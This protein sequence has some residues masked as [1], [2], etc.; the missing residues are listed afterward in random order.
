MIVIT[1][2][3]VLKAPGVR[4]GVRA[5]GVP[6]GGA[7]CVWAG[8]EHES[9]RDALDARDLDP[10]HERGPRARENRLVKLGLGGVGVVVEGFRVRVRLELREGVEKFFSSA[11]A[12][13]RLKNPR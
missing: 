4:A 3:K 9:F 6:L 12:R 10:A 1:S 2:F 13:A 5:A 11:S 7:P 8:D